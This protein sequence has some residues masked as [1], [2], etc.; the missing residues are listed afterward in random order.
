M[1]TSSVVVQAVDVMLGAGGTMG[2]AAQ[3]QRSRAM[4]FFVNGLSLGT[5]ALGYDSVHIVTP[6][7]SQ[8][9]IPALSGYAAAMDSALRMLDSAITIA[10]G[11]STIPAAW[12][13][14][15]FL[16][17]PTTEFIQLARSYKARF[18]A[19]VARTPT[20]RA[21]V[22][23][24]QVVADAAAGITADHQVTLSNAGGGWTSA[25]D[26][27]TFMT[28]SSWHQVSLM[29][30]GMADTSGA[31]QAFVNAP[32]IATMVGM[33]VLVLTPDTRWPLGETRTAQV[34]NS[35]L[36][37]PAG[38]YIANRDPGGDQP[39]NSTPLGTSQYDHRRWWA[40]DFANGNGPMVF[41]PAAEIDMLEAE[42]HIRLGAGAS[43]L[44]LVNTSRTAHGLLPYA[45]AGDLAPGGAGC[46]PRLPNGTCGTLMEA[47]KYEKRMETQLLGYMQWYNDSRGWG[48]LIVGT[49]LHWPVPYQEMQTRNQ[50]FYNMPAPGT[51][52][53]APSG[54]YGF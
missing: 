37:L 6:K 39:D 17:M 12:V 54:T 43:A 49:A 25:L 53:V 34:T 28:S 29:Y 31:Y 11:A 15:G 16:D 48:D 8:A 35:P 33:N 24:G 20:E 19:N 30:T 3:N 23:W 22:N 36:P 10:A 51:I 26:A 52:G 45:A 5:L 38:Q 4:G 1:R 18:R 2:T 44:P 47:L 46:V 41:M 32:T 14:P 21:A 13:R 27:S 42:G 40:I 7:T 9:V 50:T